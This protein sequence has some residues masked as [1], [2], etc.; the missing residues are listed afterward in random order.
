MIMEPPNWLL[1]SG[2]AQ[3]TISVDGKTFL[4]IPYDSDSNIARAAWRI[5]V[6]RKNLMQILVQCES[7]LPTKVACTENDYSDNLT[8]RDLKDSL[9]AGSLSAL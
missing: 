1:K 5:T 8:K 9:S 2:N 3:I 4:L 6:L 7:V